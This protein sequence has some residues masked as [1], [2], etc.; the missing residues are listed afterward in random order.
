MKITPTKEDFG[1]L[2]GDSKIVSETKPSTSSIT[3]SLGRITPE[4][5]SLA[6]FPIFSLDDISVRFSARINSRHVS[7][8]SRHVFAMLS[9]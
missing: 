6:G 5:L 3:P 2:T 7:G 4:S 9:I 1:N 8:H